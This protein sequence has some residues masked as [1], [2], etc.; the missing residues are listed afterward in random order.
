MT[1]ILKW[2]F[3]PYFSRY[4]TLMI[5]VMAGSAIKYDLSFWVWI[6]VLMFL[7]VVGYIF[8]CMVEKI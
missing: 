2:I 3:N 4:D 5:M 8:Q 1:A 7:I 6:P